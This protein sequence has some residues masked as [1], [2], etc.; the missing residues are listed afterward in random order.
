M[1]LNHQAGRHARYFKTRLKILV[2]R[3]LRQHYFLLTLDQFTCCVSRHN[4]RCKQIR[5]QIS[6]RV[7]FSLDSKESAAKILWDLILTSHT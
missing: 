2:D 1:P 6:A 4:N 3:A 5:S 7:L